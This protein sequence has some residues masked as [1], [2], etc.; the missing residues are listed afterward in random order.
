MT[1]TQRQ[2]GHFNTSFSSSWGGKGPETGTG[3]DVTDQMDLTLIYR[4]FYSVINYQ[5]TFS[6]AAHGTF[7]ET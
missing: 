5:Y 3:D 4:P 7:S 6:S 1:L 2:H